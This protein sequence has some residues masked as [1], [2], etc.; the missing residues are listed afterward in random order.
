MPV[1]EAVRTLLSPNQVVVS[2]VF[3][4]GL[5]TIALPRRFALF[6]LFIVAAYITLGQYVSFAGANFTMVRIIIIFCLIRAISRGDS[7]HINLNWLDKTMI[8]WAVSSIITYTILYQSG[9]AFINR[10]G[11]CFDTAG[12]YLVCRLYCSGPDDI[13]RILRLCAVLVIPLT[14]AMAIEF[15]T[16]RNPFSF[17][18]GVPLVSEVRY[19]RVRCQGSFEHPI[20]MGTFGAAMLPLIVTLWWQKGKSKLPT[21]AGSLS[22]LVIVVCSGSSGALMATVYGMIGLCAWPLRN[23]MKNVRWLMVLAIIILQFSMK[24]PLW[25]ILARLSSLT[26]GTGWHRAYLIDQAIRYFNEWGLIGTK[27]TAHWMPTGI[28]VDPNNT[29]ITNQYLVQGVHGGMITM[30]LFIAIVALG[31]AG[32]GKT[33]RILEKEDFSVRIVVWAMGASLFAH[34]ISFVSVSYFDQIQ[35]FWYFLMAAIAISLNFATAAEVKEQGNVRRNR[36]GATFEK[37]SAHV[38]SSFDRGMV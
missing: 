16:G 1:P 28:L 9:H 26:G 18:G 27:V 21:I 20:L 30:V 14:I 8:A 33:V 32:V 24:A 17:L 2:G 3:A 22:C 4:L 37:R 5:A 34:A 6:P 36:I 13:T 23:R 7:I 31:F 10:V 38:H 25:Y 12:V 15:R 11:M 29:D 35:V 19:G